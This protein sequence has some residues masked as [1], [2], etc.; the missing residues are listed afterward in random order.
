MNTAVSLQSV[1]KDF[2]NVTVVDHLS[3]DIRQGEFFSLLGASGCGKTTTLRII[4]GLERPT[5][6]TI[7]INGT[8]CTSLPPNERPV[9]T[10]FQSYALFEHLSVWENVAFG[11]R[12]KKVKGSEL[13][14]RVGD[15]LDL[16]QLPHRA[17]AR[18]DELSGGQRQRIALARAL[19]NRPQVLLLDEPLAAL[20]MKL[21][22]SMQLELKAMQREL[23]ITFIFVTHDQDEALS[24]SDRLA[25]LD[26]GTIQQ[27]GTPESMYESPESKFVAN[28]IG[29]S[30]ILPGIVD[31]GD[32][33]LFGEV[34]V[35]ASVP[36]GALTGTEVDLCLRP[37]NLTIGTES[38]RPAH[39]SGFVRDTVYS[40]PTTQHIIEIRPG[41][42]VSVVVGNSDRSRADTEWQ[43]GSRV[44]V[45][46][47]PER[48]RVLRS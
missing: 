38:T 36:D 3:L 31:G 32:I 35:P 40:G 33:L 13:S 37:E 14:Q 22:H 39:L 23:G 45:S 5:S 16:V 26:K 8:D 43:K 10:V 27:C 25:V 46:W 29:T 19:V 24:M 42:D 6:G 30:S 34:R 9:N 4:S 1:C 47:D 28:F 12:R 44:T 20:D 18:P 41:H 17:D 7:S 11:L 2:G 21:R 15:A 48:A